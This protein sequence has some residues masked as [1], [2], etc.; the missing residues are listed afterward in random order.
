MTIGDEAILLHSASAIFPLF[1]VICCSTIF[2]ILACTAGT[3]AIKRRCLSRNANKVR[4]F[5]I[6]KGSAD[7]KD[8][9]VQR[10]AWAVDIGS[11][12]TKCGLS[13]PAVADASALDISP[14]FLRLLPRFQKPDFGIGGATVTS[15]AASFPGSS[16]SGT[17]KAHDVL[18]PPSPKAVDHRR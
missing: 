17:D 10:A 3:V 2:F 8:S 12:H 15:A 16:S 9:A 1:L 4:P 7:L 18:Y 5:V 13:P 11:P 6:D 14:A